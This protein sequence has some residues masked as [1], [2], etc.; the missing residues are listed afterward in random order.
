MVRNIRLKFF[1]LPWP[2][3]YL[4]NQWVAWVVMMTDTVAESWFVRFK[5]ETIVDQ[6]LANL[7]ELEARLEACHDWRCTQMG[8]IQRNGRTR[9]WVIWVPSNLNNNLSK[10]EKLWNAQSNTSLGINPAQ[11]CA[12]QL[13]YLLSHNRSNSIWWLEQRI[14]WKDICAIAYDLNHFY[15]SKIL[16][17][18]EYIYFST[19]T[20]EV[21]CKL[22]WVE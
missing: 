15:P 16:K 9:C 19:T 5:R 11:G 13:T 12:N 21:D 4:S 14:F 7:K 8:L 3:T 1:E 18:S 6:K 22:L 10:P 2:R 20:S 17:I